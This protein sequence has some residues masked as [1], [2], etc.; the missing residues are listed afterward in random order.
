MLLRCC[1]IH[2]IIIILRHILYLVN[3]CLCLGLG[4]FMSY[5]NMDEEGEKFSDSKSSA[6]RCCLAFA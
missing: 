4:P 2:I 1:L 6:S 5:D 3:L